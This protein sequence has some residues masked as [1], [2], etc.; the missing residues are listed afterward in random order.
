MVDIGPPFLALAIAITEIPDDHI[1]VTIAIHIPGRDGRRTKLNADLVA[2]G[3]PAGA[4]AQPGGRTVIDKSPPFGTLAIARCP[5]NHI[6]VTIAIHISGCT[7]RDAKIGADLVALY[8][9]GGSSAQTGRRAVI[10]EDL[11]FVALT[12]GIIGH[13]NDH[14]GITVAVHIPGCT[15]RVAKAGAG[16]VAIG[17]PG[18]SGAQ[19]GRRPMVDIGPSFINLTI[20]IVLCPDDHI[21]VTIAIHISGRAGREAKVGE[22]LVALGRPIGRSA[23]TRDR[24]VVDKDPPF[25]NLA[26][27]IVIR[28]DDHIGVAITVHIPGRTHRPSEH[29]IG[30]VALG[31]PGGG[32]SQRIDG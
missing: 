24:A 25:A 18:R 11:P 32:G 29:G 20:I 23:Q 14:I 1:D 5:D 13:P 6:G 22:G 10:N 27:V 9:P 3:C 15:Y 26:V 4:G 28:P 16:L 17:C 30:L 2:I 7:H 12:V 31:R 8:R 19:T 21:G